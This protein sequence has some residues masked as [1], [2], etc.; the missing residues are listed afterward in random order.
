MIKKLP[1]A[2]ALL[3]ALALTASAA[4]RSISGVLP[5]G[6]TGSPARSSGDK[7]DLKLWYDREAN[8]W[9]SEALP[10]GNGH[11]GAMLFGGVAAE[12]VQFNEESLWVGDEDDTGA[13]QN[14]GELRLDFDGEAGIGTVTNPS[15]HD[16]SADIVL[17]D[18][19]TP[20]P[21]VHHYRRELDL[22]SA[23][24]RVTYERNG[25]HYMREAF[26]SFPAKVIAWRITADRPGVIAAN[27]SISDAHGAK[28]FVDGNTIT[29]QG[30]IPGHSYDGGKTWPALHYE[31][32]VRAIPQGGKILTTGDGLR[33]EGADSLV[34]L[35]D[36]GTDFAQSHEKNWR[37][38]LPHAVV[39][40]HLDAAASRGWQK[41]LAEHER[42]YRRLF[43]RVNLD[44]G[45][46]PSSLPTDHRL[47]AYRVWQ[48][49]LGLEELL[50]QY[51][52][53]LMIASSREGGLPANL[54]GKW[55][56][57]NHPPW[58]SDYHTD[59]NVEMNYWLT[60]PA[61]LSECFEPYAAWINS[62]REVRQAATKEAFNYRGWTM[63]G[64]SGLFGGS[65]WDWVPGSSAWLMQNTYDHY[66]FSGDRIYLQKFAYPAM[67][68]VCEFT[69]D[70]LKAL[71]D[72]T[73]VTTQ[74]FSPEHGPKEDGVSF[75]HELAWDLFTSTIEASEILGRDADFRAQLADKR[76][77]LLGPKIGKWGQLQEWMTDRD[78][79]HDTHRHLSHLIAV[80][81]GRQISPDTTPALANAARVSLTARGDD[82]T[83]WST[84]W[85]INQWARLLDGDHAHKLF[86]NLLRPCFKT[87]ME[88]EGGGLYGNL[89]D[90][91]PPF[92]IDGNFGFTAGV[93]EMLLQSHL[94]EIRLLPALPKAWPTGSFAGLCARGG[95]DLDL[96]WLDGKP[97]NLVV[98]S[99][100][101][102]EFRLKSSGN[103]QVR[104][105]GAPVTIKSAESDVVSFSTRPGR[106]YEITFPTAK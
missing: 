87:T 47:A 82:S 74:G 16:S 56:D 53:Y 5:V 94:G 62:I 46:N 83:G 12:R 97:V 103:L 88:N 60:D 77:H 35:L 101:G 43:D 93:C 23:V 33:V 100:A 30:A 11:M 85:K 65:T 102:Q 3:A 63:R 14:F 50:F 2:P 39:N 90:A 95:F 42:D 41:L 24:Q 38:A 44:L 52:R 80:H 9:M 89:F 26:A 66:R 72:G 15:Q 91:C 22:N 59:I 73:L 84:A 75:D 106:V 49:D 96:T 57:S 86:G 78:D 8:K 76:T 104:C 45:A 25:V 17:G 64:E 28:P 20:D 37:G 70:R 7:A 54:Q 13:Y 19:A 69:L 29:T 4:P 40:H 21:S 36:A 99:K 51:G 58:R 55:N 18:F 68:E 32:Q 67:K 71:P 10:I 79:P 92:Q 6:T 61:N 31:S 48:P 1:F 105:N 27:L 98:R 81:P 34:V